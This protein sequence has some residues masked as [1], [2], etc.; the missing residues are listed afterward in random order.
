M[1]E[2]RP[3][4]DAADRGVAARRMMPLAFAAGSLVVVVAGGALWLTLS[5]PLP[6]RGV[7]VA[8]PTPA[9]APLP[10]SAAPEPS[11]AAPQPATVKAEPPAVATPAA[12]TPAAESPAAPA[13]AATASNTPASNTPASDKPVP[14]ADAPQSLLPPPSAQDTPPA[15]PPGFSHGQALAAAPDADLIERVATGYLP[16]VGRDGRLPWQVYAR[17]FDL[18]DKRPR[19]A[20]IITALGM[21]ATQTDAAINRLPAAVTLAFQPYARKLGE[22]INL[23]RAAGHEVLLTL[24]ME[25]LDYPRNDPGP[26]PLLTALE[27]AKNLERFNWVMSQGTGYVGLVGFEGSRYT[28][29]H[30]DMMP[31]LDAMKRRGLLY[32]DNRETPQTVVPALAGELKLPFASSNR[33]IDRDATRAGIDKRLAELEDIARRNGA[34][35]GIGSP[36]PVTFERVAVW[37]QGLEDR[38]L[39]LA[40]VSAVIGKTKEQVP[41]KGEQQ[42]GEPPAAGPG[43][44][45]EGEGAAPANKD[46]PASKDSGKDTAA[47][48]T[49]P[50]AAAKQE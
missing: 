42:K 12:E 10:T 49:K 3:V 23:S 30:D 20:M 28:A 31:I 26:N 14:A 25:P 2:R 41:Q 44:G 11:A 19:V 47:A 40:P 9:T 16:V 18:A 32:V 39:V 46:T 24:P 5:G 7:T 13:P 37:A 50:A 22:W 17:P 8:L 27:P 45:K 48:G 1:A 4:P 15:P 29:A 33:T 34:A 21:S 6:D 43:A 38:G 35:V 36:F